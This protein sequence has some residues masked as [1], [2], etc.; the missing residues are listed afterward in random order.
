MNSVEFCQIHKKHLLTWSFGFP[1]SLMWWITLINFRMSYQPCVPSLCPIL[2][3]CIILYIY[4]LLNSIFWLFFGDFC[5]YDYYWYWSVTFFSYD[6]FFRFYYQLSW[7]HRVRWKVFFIFWK[8]YC[9]IHIISFLNSG[10]N[11]HWN[12]LSLEF[13]LWK[14]FIVSTTIYAPKLNFYIIPN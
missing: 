14:R 1:P 8:Q 13:S 10:S 6:L 11:C 7:C 3:W 9:K 2:S 4:I 5:V 12:H